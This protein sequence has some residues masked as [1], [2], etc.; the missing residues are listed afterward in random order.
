M[1]KSKPKIAVVT[2]AYIPEG[3]V[4]YGTGIRSVQVPN[5]YEH[6]DEDKYAT[7]MFTL[8]CYKHYK[9]GMDYDLFVIDNSSPDKSIKDIEEYCKE[10]NIT[11][12]KRENIGF[13]FGAFRYVFEKYWQNY[14]Y[15]LFHQANKLMNE[16]IRKKLKIEPEKV[17]YSLQNYGN[18]SS[19]SIPLTIVTELAD[20]LKDK[21]SSLV[22]SAFGVGFSWASAAI[23]TDNLICLP[24]LEIE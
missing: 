13:S 21:K 8:S 14:D 1:E 4:E 2:C 15:F 5:H 12:E 6:Y 22:L 18:T 10:N 24:L 3:K 20:S 11:F 16:C 7:L 19:A 9:S 17:P 23:S